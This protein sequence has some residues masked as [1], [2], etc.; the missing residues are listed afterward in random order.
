MRHMTLDETPV[1]QPLFSKVLVAN[2]GEIARRI[3]RCLRTLNIPSAVVYHDSDRRSPAV[4]EA[5]QA[6][7]ISG[8]SPAAAYLDIEQILSVCDH[9]GVEAVHP[10]YGF[11]AEN[12]AFARALAEAGIT[13]I[14]PSAEIMELM[15]DK[16][17]A[18]QFVAAQGLPVP[19]S[20]DLD[21]A[22]PGFAEA[23][24][25]LGFP[26]VV[27]ASAGGGGKG[28]NIVRQADELEGALRIAASEA[29]RYF[30]DGRVYVERYFTGIRHIEVQVLGDG[31][32]AVHV[33]ERE[34]S[35]QRRFQ[36]VIEEAPSPAVDDAMRTRLGAAAVGIAEA[37]AY[38]GAGTVEFLHTAK[39]EFF[40]LEMNTRIQVEHP[41]TELVYGVDLVAEQLRI[42]ARE[43][44]RLRQEN[45]QP[46]GHAIECR[47]CAEDP[48][49]GFLPETGRVAHL[50]EP[51]GEG[52]RMD[53]GLHPGQD[54]TAAFDP[55]LG[56]LIAHGATRPAAIAKAIAALRETVVLGV[57]T[58]AAYLGAILAH[59]AFAEGATDTEFLDRHGDAL[60]SQAPPADAIVR[61][62]A[63]A[64]LADRQTRLIDNAMPA[65][66]AALGAWRN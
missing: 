34:C 65:L 54:V 20:V 15:G 29:S 27:K 11:L 19:P 22:D 4:A 7:E 47:L 57:R 1:P 14:G 32:R 24:A 60:L 2:R 55:L 38:Q 48:A 5:D 63:A 26:V 58:N 36:K 42:A 52:I 33:G 35:V 31:E 44:L 23:A 64:H 25:S 13:F 46:D 6:V 17:A 10:G 3:L 62:L 51:Q 49:N 8:A 16:I 41:V 66:H 28:M 53:S 45:L 39:G 9:L 21:P 12:P 30:G 43:P 18:R 37:A 61:A 40:F 50:K 56:K 59:P